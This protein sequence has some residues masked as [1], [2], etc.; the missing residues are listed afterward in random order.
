MYARQTT[1]GATRKSQHPASELEAIYKDTHAHPELSMKETR[2]A[3]IAETHLKTMGFE[4]TAG[5]GKTGVVGLLRNA[6]MIP[7]VR[8]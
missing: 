1:R 2:T 6:C 5:V 7:L 8:R 3:R 4:V